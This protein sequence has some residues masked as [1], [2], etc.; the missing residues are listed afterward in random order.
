MTSK[1][2]PVER[3]SPTHKRPIDDA[4]YWL[5]RAEE[6]RIIAD[7]MIDPDT[8]LMMLDLAQTDKEMADRAYQRAKNS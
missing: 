1:P 7:D 3:F 5:D 8:R 2:A 6:L 4:A